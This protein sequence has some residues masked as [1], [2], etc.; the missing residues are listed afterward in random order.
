MTFGFVRYVSSSRAMPLSRELNPLFWSEVHKT[1][2]LIGRREARARIVRLPRNRLAILCWKV[3][4]GWFVGR[5]MI[6]APAGS[7]EPQS[8]GG[9]E[10]PYCRE[11]IF[12]FHCFA[13]SKFSPAILPD[14]WELTS[15]LERRR[16]ILVPS[17]S[18][19]ER[20]GDMKKLR[21]YRN[22]SFCWSSRIGSVVG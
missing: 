5:R 3:S 19:E 13:F 15:N 17:A 4:G 22:S 6:R 7:G 2:R 16:R 20:A 12:S 10:H 1:P 18:E 21:L 14:F 9:K 11:K 8:T